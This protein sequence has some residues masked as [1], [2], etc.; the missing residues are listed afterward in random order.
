VPPQSPRFPIRLLNAR[1]PSPRT[2]PP[3]NPF[4]DALRCHAFD[5][6]DLGS[7]VT[8]PI[9]TAVTYLGAR[10][11]DESFTCGW[12]PPAQTVS[13]RAAAPPFC[14]PNPRAACTALRVPYRFYFGH[15]RSTCTLIVTK[16]STMLAVIVNTT[17]SSAGT[18]T[19]R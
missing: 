17:S 12:R 2:F 4:P 9:V 16:K 14:E 10:F 1:A 3:N 19:R 15:E 13:L 18:N 7:C 8:T 6:W 11:G 5:S